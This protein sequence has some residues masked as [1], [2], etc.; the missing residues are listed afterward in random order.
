MPNII[1]RDIV[2]CNTV[3]SLD[4]TDGRQCQK[5]QT[6]IADR[7]RHRKSV[8]AKSSYT[9][10][11]I[12]TKPNYTIQDFKNGTESLTIAEGVTFSIINETAL[13]EEMGRSL[14]NKNGGALRA[15]TLK[16]REIFH[17]YKETERVGLLALRQ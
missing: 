6:G 16:L 5:V 1:R 10:P 13:L 11:P 4:L 3:L 7:I 2:F 12:T 17:H 9:T 8:T 15:W 14:S